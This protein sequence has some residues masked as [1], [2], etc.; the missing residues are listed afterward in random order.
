MRDCKSCQDVQTRRNFS[1]ND[2]RDGSPSISH[3]PPMRMQPAPSKAQTRTSCR[4]TAH[5]QC[6]CTL[7]SRLHQIG[8]PLARC[9]A[10]RVLLLR[11]AT[12]SKVLRG[13]QAVFSIHGGDVR[14][15]PHTGHVGGRLRRQ[16]VHKLLQR[17]TGEV[18]ALPHLARRRLHPLRDSACNYR[19]RVQSAH[20]TWPALAAATAHR[21]ETGV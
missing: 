21:M 20:T 18:H 13:L 3:H 7:R 1:V 11:Q 12:L 2:A 15:T 5:S 14:A 9:A 17:V 16:I 4:I 6:S 19:P 10:T 8:E